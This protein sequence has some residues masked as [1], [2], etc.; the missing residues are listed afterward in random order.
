MNI[1]HIV[2]SLSLGGLQTFSVD[3]A[4]QQVI[5]GNNV[6]IVTL[7]DSSKDYLLNRVDSRIVIV[8]LKCSIK[9]YNLFLMHKIIKLLDACSTSIIHTHGI[10]LYFSFMASLLRRK[11][12]FVHTVH[13]LAQNEAGKVRRWIARISYRCGLSFPVTIS[14]EVSESF[15][16][17]YPKISFRQINNGLSSRL[18]IDI[19]KKEH[20]KT[21]LNSLK[22]DADTKI[23]LSVGRIDYQKNRAMLLDAFYKF[24]AQRNVVLAI[25]G[26]PIDLENPFYGTL[27]DH[28]VIK[29]KK[30]YFLGLKSNI[31]DYLDYSDYFCLTSI[32]EGLPISVLEAMRAGLV[33]ICTPAGGITSLLKDVG[34]ISSGFSL[35]SFVNALVDSESNSKSITSQ[36]VNNHFKN[37]WSMD[38]CAGNYLNLYKK[39]S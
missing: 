32:F 12:K 28:P 9:Y 7:M 21:E 3:L 31:H 33:C 17:Y 25:I 1:I 23:Y 37:K 13:N 16:E 10:S 27:V 30:A 39:L 22:F 26:G 5:E 14:D 35:D 20:A 19:D 24:S 11:S 29:E 8:N 15:Q 6:K 38:I 36:K 18:D 34:Y 4:N 2:P